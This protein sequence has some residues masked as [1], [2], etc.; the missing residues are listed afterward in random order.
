MR[1][2]KLSLDWHYHQHYHLRPQNS[3]R[4]VDSERLVSPHHCFDHHFLSP[5]STN[6]SGNFASLLSAIT[7]T[8]RQL[9]LILSSTPYFG[10]HHKHH[11]YLRPLGTRPAHIH[12]FGP[13]VHFKHTPTMYIQNGHHQIHAYLKC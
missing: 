6:Y 3:D 11:F 13:H 7:R 10:L 8:A 9:A 2:I 5:Y 1:L 4:P 12:T